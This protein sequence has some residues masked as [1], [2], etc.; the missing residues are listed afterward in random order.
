[1]RALVS[2]SIVVMLSASMLAAQNASFDCAKATTPIE[3][4][5]CADPALG[6]LDGRLATV[7]AEA[8]KN[9]DP[10]YIGQAKWLRDERSTCAT[11][12]DPASCLTYEYNER[13]HALESLATA[14][15]YMSPTNPNYL[16][17]LKPA[18]QNRVEI[19]TLQLE[20][21]AESCLP[22]SDDPFS[23]TLDPTR[24][25]ASLTDDRG[26]TL[27]LTFDAQYATLTAKTDGSR[28]CY[29][30]IFRQVTPA[31]LDGTYRRVSTATLH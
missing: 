23:T 21:R 20:E 5:I 6:T 14:V 25:I 18:D 3:K 26:S 12:K 22:M 16:L 24:R 29:G 7:Y 9:V 4:T 13:I 10:K 28:F 2:L 15:V 27:E 11:R 17:A 19:S 8:K 31:Y 30:S 1:M